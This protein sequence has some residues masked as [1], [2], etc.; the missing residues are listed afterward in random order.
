[1]QSRLAGTATRWSWVLAQANNK[2]ALRRGLASALAGRTADPPNAIH[3]GEVEAGPA[4]AVHYRKPE[5][6]GNVVDA[7]TEN[8][9]IE[10][11]P[12]KETGPL[13]PPGTP[14]G[15]PP[16][17]E[18][19]GL[20]QASNPITQQKRSH[21][22]SHATSLEKVSCAGLDGTPWPEEIEKEQSDRERQAEDDREYYK[23]HKASPLSEIKMVDTR[24][25][26]TRVTDASKFE[27][28]GDVIGWRPEQLDTAEEALLRAV[29]IWR[30]NAMRGDPDLPHGRV[31]RELRGE[32]F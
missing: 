32:W 9:E 6:Q 27:V 11:K 28:G 21:S 1:M 14:Y 22:H 15:S 18:S 23:H 25:P 16:R 5:G 13:V 24:K 29:R 12:S 31:L 3:S 17:L 26:I 10:L 4:H 7:D 8:Q 30:Q 20:S 19:T 2:Q